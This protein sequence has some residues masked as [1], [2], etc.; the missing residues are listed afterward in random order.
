MDN[1]LKITLP[2]IVEDQTDWKL[3]TEYQSPIG[4]DP[5][6]WYNRLI[7]RILMFFH[8]RTERLWHWIWRIARPFKEPPMRYETKYR[9]MKVIKKDGSNVIVNNG[10][11][12]TDGMPVFSEKPK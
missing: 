6:K 7:W 5:W 12:L 11:H 8:D 10:E 3:Y 1:N 9:E 4:R 2:P